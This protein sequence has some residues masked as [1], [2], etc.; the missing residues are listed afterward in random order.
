MK[1]LK[2]II[3]L[4]TVL[5]SATTSAQDPQPKHSVGLYQVMTDYNV[6]LLDRKYF[7][8]D[9]SFSQSTRIAYQN[10]V[11][12]SW[13]LNAGISN[14]F[15]NNQT[16][17]DRFLN[18]AYA[19][20]IDGA[21][22]YKTNNGHIFKEQAAFAPYIAFGY[23]LDYI[24]ALK[25]VDIDPMVLLNQYAIGFNIRLNQRSHIQLQAAIDQKLKDDFNTHLQYRIGI[26][27][28]LGPLVDR[29]KEL[30]VEY[31]DPTAGDNVET[32]DMTASNCNSL[33]TQLDSM[34]AEITELKEQN[35]IQL[36]LI[37][38]KNNMIDHLLD[39]INHLR[40][41]VSDIAVT[42]VP[43]LT[44]DSQ[45]LE[46]IEDQLEGLNYYA[47]VSTVKDLKVAQDLLLNIKVDFNQ[48]FI[49][50]QS[51]GFYRVGVYA[52][53]D[54][55]TATSVLQQVKAKGY[56]PVWLSYE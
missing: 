54:Y 4:V 47:I 19:F 9:S 3:I 17:N 21:I 11:S 35:S 45:D 24:H 7:A 50:K 46:P 55:V 23:R 37:G 40:T 42:P 28:S 2:T 6:V 52:G 33:L 53:K 38:E 12:K 18:K 13:V 36:V 49:L 30:P 39:S 14:G 31:A 26:T 22:Q 43:D 56:N 5:I 1:I 29:I 10:L 27:Q 25:K 16:L 44:S 32:T 51:T 48:S 41:N 20:G 8:F 34:I 15:I